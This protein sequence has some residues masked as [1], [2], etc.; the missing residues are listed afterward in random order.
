MEEELL[1]VGEVARR[2][3]TTVSAIRY[4]DERGLVSPRTRVR[5]QRRYR[6]AEV[7]RLAFVRMWQQT[8]LFSLDDLDALMSPA[9]RADWRRVARARIADLREQVAAAEAAQRYIEWMLTCSRQDI[10]ECPVCQEDL[11]AWLALDR[12]HEKAPE[13]RDETRLCAVCREPLPPPG[14]GRP[15]LYCSG[16]CRQRAHR[17]CTWPSPRASA[18]PEEEA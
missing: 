1:G 6:P 4:Y 7:R 5:G 3:G 17:G 15:R 2:L 11:D 10:T 16:R 8:G 14:R 18:H 9:D 12:R 13:P